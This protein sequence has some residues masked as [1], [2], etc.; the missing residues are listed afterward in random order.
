MKKLMS[1]GRAR[2]TSELKRFLEHLRLFELLSRTMMSASFPSAMDPVRAPMPRSR[3][4]SMV[5]MRKVMPVVAHKRL[6]GPLH[7]REHVGPVDHHVV[8][9]QPEQQPRFRHLFHRRTADARRHVRPG[10]DHGRQAQV[11]GPGDVP[12]RRMGHVD[13]EVRPELHSGFY[14]ASI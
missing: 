7:L 4:P 1:S 11:G 8:R 2:L 5:A 3:A 10:A 14:V 6:G 9:A 12:V 13:Q